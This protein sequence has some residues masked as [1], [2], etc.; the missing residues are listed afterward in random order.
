MRT[1]DLEHALT[2]S[3]ELLAEPDL[4][5]A[6]SRLDRR[7][8]RARRSRNGVLSVLAIAACAGVIASVLILA[9]RTGGTKV[10]TVP[11]ATTTSTTSATTTSV[12]PSYLIPS[13]TVEQ[14]PWNLKVSIDSSTGRDFIAPTKAELAGASPET[15]TVPGEIVAH[16]VC[17]PTAS[18]CYPLAQ[19]DAVV[20]R[21]WGFSGV[22]QSRPPAGI[23]AIGD[24]VARFPSPAL[25]RNYIQSIANLSDAGPSTPIVGISGATYV[26]VPLATPIGPPGGSAVTAHTDYIFIDRGDYV[27]AVAVLG[28]GS[29]P[30]PADAA[31]LARL[32]AAYAPTDSLSSVNSGPATGSSERPSHPS[33]TVDQGVTAVYLGSIARD[34]IE[35]NTGVTLEVPSGNDK[36]SISWQQAVTQCVPDGLSCDRGGSTVRVSIAFVDAPGGAPLLDQK[37]VYVFAWPAG[38]CSPGGIT[39]PSNITTTSHPASCMAL[40]FVDAKTGESGTSLSGLSLTDPSAG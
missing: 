13:A 19:A 28:D 3:R 25:A 7:I 27:L 20:E 39:Y 10:V 24:T 1:E 29:R 5:Q 37:L 6:R 34:D 17:R 14:A 11:P 32:Q 23:L 8:R 12:L 40:S 15:S 21:Q 31:A 26:S 18:S 35:A 2:A 22:V 30:T 4:Q 9:N 33:T 36:P 38:T 16:V